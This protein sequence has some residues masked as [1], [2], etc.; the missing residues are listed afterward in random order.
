M[1][2]V[3]AF[4]AT[5]AFV[6]ALARKPTEP[7]SAPLPQWA[8]ILHRPG[9]LGA[10][11][12]IL[13][14]ANAG[15]HPYGLVLSFA[16]GAVEIPRNVEWMQWNSYSRVRAEK[17]MHRIPEMWGP[18]DL[19]PRIEVDQ[20]WMNIDGSASTSIYRFS[21]NLH[22]IDFLKYDITNL[23]YYIRDQGRAAIIGV[24]G[25][26]DLLSAYLFGF[27]H[28]TGIEVNTIFINLLNGPFR[29]FNRLADL[30]G[31]EFETDDARSW[32]ANRGHNG[33]FDLVQMSMVDTWAATSV[34]AFSLSE[35]G[36]YTVQGWRHFLESLTPNGVFT[37]SRWYDQNNPIETGRLLSLAKAT[38]SVMGISKPTNHLFLASTGNLA[39]LI[40]AHSPL[41]RQD[42]ANLHAAADRLGFSILISPD[43]PRQNAT[44]REIVEAS[45]LNA[46]KELTGKYHID[47]TPPTDERPFFFHQLPITDLTA[48]IRATRAATTGVIGGNLWA[49]MTLLFIILSSLVL[50]VLTIIIPAVP[51]MR[52]GS[53]ELIGIGTSY[54]LLIGIGFM[55][56]EIAV[57]QRL[58]LFLGHPVY[59]LAIGLFAIILSTGMGSLISDHLPINNA[60]RAMFWSVLTAI[61]LVVLPFCL[62]TLLSVSEGYSIFVR[63]VVAVLIIAPCGLLMGFGFPTGMRLINAIDTR[64]TPWF[65]AING[66]AGVLAASIAVA[67]NIAFSINV[68]IWIA[69]GCYLLVGMAA[70]A[71]VN[72]ATRK[73]TIAVG[74]GPALLN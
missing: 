45:D 50:V 2:M 53:I 13:A 38:L 41:S 35:N 31:V 39:T 69:A 67:V 1:L 51:S 16:K 26:R 25:G 34:G 72:A 61:Y 5:A 21:G 33:Q 9:T 65:W 22:E 28:V 54:F 73:Q 66:A 30:S 46:L 12:A 11:F 32:F 4:G 48:M 10:V 36:L 47:L 40:V 52:E 37:V 27:R 60:L 71:L 8:S 59:G 58:S 64:P 49:T 62:P 24:G 19:M 68:S 14:L 15:I 3:S 43:R 55:F 63:A 7:E 74:S 42:L 44:L 17:T 56:V 29:E 23:A 20:R 18:S 70:V 57:I 6:F